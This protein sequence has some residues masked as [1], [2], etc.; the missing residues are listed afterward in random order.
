MNQDELNK[1][2]ENHNH[3][4]NEDCDD[5]GRMKADLEG[6]NLSGL[7]L[8]FVDLSYANLSKTNLNGAN[9]MFSNLRSVHFKNANLES[10]NF[11]G[12]D[13]T[14]TDLRYT[15]LNKA[16]LNHTN[17]QGANLKEANLSNTELYGAN[18]RYAICDV[19]SIGNIGSRRD[20]TYYF[21][22][23]DRVICGCFDGTMNEF[24]NKIKDTY[25]KN[26]KHYEEYMLAV[27][28]LEKMAKLE[29]SFN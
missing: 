26:D 24:K 10:A 3:W 6:D 27:E 19:V 16:K 4:M 17:L 29:G 20:T 28:Y 23:D 12:A 9:L 11:E 22:K 25:E 5:W 7:N 15:N 13:L 1:I 8:N 18:F 14:K 21:Y 2:L